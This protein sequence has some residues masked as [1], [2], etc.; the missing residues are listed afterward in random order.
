MEQAEYKVDIK[1]E[2]LNPGIYTLPCESRVIDVIEKA[3][4]LTQNANTTVINLS[5]KISDEM[6]IIIYS[7]EEVLSFEETKAKEKE[8]IE[9]CIQKEE[10]ALKN[11][12]CISTEEENSQ[13]GKISL[14]QATKEDLMK[15]P[16]IGE[17]KADLI[18]QYR[19]EHGSFQTIEEVKEVSGIGESIF[20]KIKDYLIL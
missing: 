4:G 12:A 18:I 17:S 16:G 15:L 5:K 20:E 10:N 19:K 3:G 6:V 1:G 9:H 2:V 13:V 7:N 14:N 8:V 11:D